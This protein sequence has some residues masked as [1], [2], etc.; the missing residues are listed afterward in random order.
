MLQFK[1]N[2]TAV[3]IILTLTE[4]TTLS[5]PFY[6]FS[7]THVLTK[8]VVA[9]VKSDEDDESDYPARYNQFTI[10]PETT[11]AGEQPGEWHY[12]VFEQDNA[13]N[14]DPTL[15]TGLLESGKMILDR[16]EDF[17]FELYDSPTSFKTYNG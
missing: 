17:A 5:A 6:L 4:L 15:A 13:D 2:D 3:A 14:L 1:Q 9:F 7:F 11:F 12:R 16:T 10:D 8:D